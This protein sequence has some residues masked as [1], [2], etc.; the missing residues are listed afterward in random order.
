MDNEV[1]KTDKQMIYL[2]GIGGVFGILSWVVA[3]TSKSWLEGLS[4]LALA[5]GLVV[6]L[7]YTV[8]QRK[9][10]EAKHRP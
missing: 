1:M 6:F 10:L 2:F 4:M 3:G 9:H 5:A 7:V 8:A